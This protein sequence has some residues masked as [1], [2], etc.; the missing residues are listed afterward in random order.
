[1]RSLYQGDV[2]R[3]WKIMMFEEEEWDW[4]DEDDEE[5]EDW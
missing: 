3:R 5:E 4:E 2:N 1:V